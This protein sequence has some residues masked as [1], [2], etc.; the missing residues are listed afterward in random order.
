MRILIIC[1]KEKTAIWRLADSVK[2]NLLQH[3]IIILPVHPKRNDVD[4]LLEA[5]RLLQWCDVLDIHYWKSGQVLRTNFPKEFEEKPK[6]LFHNNPY[7]AENDEN[8]YYDKVVVNNEEIYN[9]LPSAYLIPMGINLGFFKFNDNYTEDKVVNM[10]VARIEGK[11]GVLEVAKACNDLGYKFK[12]VGRVSKPEYMDEVIKVG[13][14]N[15]EFFEDVTDEKLRE[16]YYSSAIHVCNSVDNFESGTLPILEAMACGVPVLT[17]RVGHVPELYDGSNLLVRKGKEDDAEDLKTALKSLMENKEWRIKMRNKAWDT[18]KTRDERRMALE[19]N[20]I[21]YSIWRKDLSLMSVII[22]TKDRPKVFMES[23]IGA[24]QQ[25]YPKYEIIVADS[26]D[27]PVKLIVEEARKQTDTP[28]K[29]IHFPHKG[30]YTLSE[31][32]NRAVIEADGNTLVFCDDRLKME[33]T[34]VS[35]FSAYARPRTWIWGV[36]DGAPKAFVENFCC[37]NRGDLVRS[38]MFCE[39]MQWYGGM[40]QEIRERFE[41][42]LG[43]SFIFMDEA[44]ANEVRTTK[45]KSTRR[46]DLIEAKFLVY[47]MY[48]K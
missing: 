4:T 29:Y 48:K 7:E 45:K 37:I 32:R 35:V 40:S 19:V 3:K 24:L 30:N 10:S 22:P 25:D 5:Q 2:R 16:V 21:Y 43:F 23:F 26:G 28:I 14:R 6:V 17:R 13:G 41:K 34:A 46:D 15:I 42:G 27:I 12:L 18:V 31:A 38:G 44:K 33:P 11:K 47:K 1:D 8:K 36:K 20:T 39:R 9:K